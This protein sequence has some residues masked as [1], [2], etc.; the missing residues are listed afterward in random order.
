MSDSEELNNNSVFSAEE[1]SQ[2]S[3]EEHVL[4]LEEMEGREDEIEL[5]ESEDGSGEVNLSDYA[6]EDE[7]LLQ[8]AES[9]QVDPDFEEVE[10]QQDDESEPSDACLD[11]E[12]C[13]N[14]AKE[15]HDLLVLRGLQPIDKK[16]QCVAA[17]SEA[18]CDTYSQ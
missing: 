5:V 1:S 9:S 11:H 16:K 13:I 4:E 2:P 14:F 12:S 10:E 18:I 8:V 6:A 3:E 17:L 7:L 15:C